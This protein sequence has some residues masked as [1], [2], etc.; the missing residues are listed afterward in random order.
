MSNIK[1][2]QVEHEP[3]GGSITVEINYDHVSVWG[4]EK[5]ARTA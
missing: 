5:V 2:Y 1:I 4:D 3:T